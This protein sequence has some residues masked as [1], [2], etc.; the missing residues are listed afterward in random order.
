MIEGILF[1]GGLFK[2]INKVNKKYK[3]YENLE[4]TIRSFKTLFIVSLLQWVMLGFVFMLYYMHNL[5]GEEFFNQ[6]VIVFGTIANSLAFSNVILIIMLFI[7]ALLKIF[8]EDGRIWEIENDYF[9][10]EELE[11]DGI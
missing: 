7:Y 8:E 1:I 5:L 4:I 3:W 10:K 11:K 6:E 2:A 9:I